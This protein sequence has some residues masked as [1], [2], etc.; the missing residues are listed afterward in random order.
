MAAAQAGKQRYQID[1]FKTAS[2]DSF[3]KGSNRFI[4]QRLDF[5][6]L[7][8]RQLTGGRRIRVQIAYRSR[9]LKSLVENSVD[10]LN[11]LG[12]QSGLISASSFEVIV[13]LLSGMGVQLMKSEAVFIRR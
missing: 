10:A 9:L 12:R 4:V 11:R 7:H 13:K 3:Y 5:F 6:P 8:F 1:N 2:L